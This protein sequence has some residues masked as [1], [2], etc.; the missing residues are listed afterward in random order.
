[1]EGFH[2]QVS[3]EANTAIDGHTLRDTPTASN[4]TEQPGVTQPS[5]V[6]SQVFPYAP[7]A[8]FHAQQTVMQQAS[9]FLPGQNLHTIHQ[10]DPITS[11]SYHWAGQAAPQVPDNELSMMINAS[12]ISLAEF[13]A[14]NDML[15]PD[16]RQGFV[17]LSDSSSVPR[18]FPA[19]AGAS[20]TPFSGTLSSPLQAASRQAAP[21]LR[22][23]DTSQ[24]TGALLSHRMEGIESASTLQPSTQAASA[25]PAVPTNRGG[26]QKKSLSDGPRPMQP[27]HLPIPPQYG[28][29]HAGAIP[30]SVPSL[31]GLQSMNETYHSF[32]MAG[33]GSR[34]YPVDLTLPSQPWAQHTS[35]PCGFEQVAL[36]QSAGPVP[37]MQPRQPRSIYDEGVLDH[38][39]LPHSAQLPSLSQPATPVL[40]LIAPKGQQTTSQARTSPR[41]SISPKRP[42]PTGAGVR[43]AASVSSNTASAAALQAIYQRMR[44]GGAEPSWQQQERQKAEEQLIQD[45]KQRAQEELERI[46]KAN[47]EKKEARW[48]HKEA[49]AKEKADA[50][51]QRAEAKEAAKAE[52]LKNRVKPPPKKKGPAKGFKHKPRTPAAETSQSSLSLSR[53][54]PTTVPGLPT[55]ETEDDVD[56]DCDLDMEFEA[57]FRLMNEQSM[58]HQQCPESVDTQDTDMTM[59]HIPSPE[60]TEDAQQAYESESEISEEE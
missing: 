9:P 23:T 42:S 10:Q 24:Q 20:P 18:L 14:Y 3:A 12:S 45:E 40:D 30:R 27:Y 13:D 4:Q 26:R 47:Q 38:A 29:T 7:Q 37:S 55:P 16:W 57:A 58:N 8:Q 50:R 51:I 32:N 34:N 43:K 19:Y 15:Q 2:A 36:R 53:S 11:H 52:E 49:V 46:E 41:K 31:P 6:S 48:R 35:H 39:L 5:G 33:Q 1:M 44:V 17:G 25:V 22:F 60:S 21:G 28:C 54:S 59:D 56:E